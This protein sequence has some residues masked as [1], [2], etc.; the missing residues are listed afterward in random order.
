MADLYI[1]PPA[2]TKEELEIT[3]ATEAARNELQKVLPTLQV[4]KNSLFT[5]QIRISAIQTTINYLKGEG[6]HIVSIKEYNAIKKALPEMVA[7]ENKFKM[8][9]EFLSALANSLEAKIKKNEESLTAL[10]KKNDN[11]IEFKKR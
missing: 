5:I 11:V 10:K 4:N 2:L 3:V 9:V 1:P 8:N 7:E 6:A